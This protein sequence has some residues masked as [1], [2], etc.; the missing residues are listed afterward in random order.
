M[1]KDKITP[2][3]GMFEYTD[4]FIYKSIEWLPVNT[5]GHRDMPS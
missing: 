2:N 3:M 5:D 4:D 1:K